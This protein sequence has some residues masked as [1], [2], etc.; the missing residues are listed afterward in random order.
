MQKKRL[1]KIADTVLEIYEGDLL[2]IRIDESNYELDKNEELIIDR[3]LCNLIS[4]E[5]WNNILKDIDDNYI[6]KKKWKKLKRK[7]KNIF[8]D[9]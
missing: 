5:E 1:F 9:K 8:C 3:K 6:I 4:D 7:N 2:T